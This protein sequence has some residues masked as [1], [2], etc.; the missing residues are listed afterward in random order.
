MKLG[1]HLVSFS[2]ARVDAEEGDSDRI[3]IIKIVDKQSSL[4]QAK[5]EEQIP[6]NAD[7]QG[8]CKFASPT[9][10]TYEKLYKR[11]GRMVE[12]HVE[13]QLALQCM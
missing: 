8:I 1:M 7:H 9:D 2:Y 4:L 5:V 6:V 10:E 11:M 13:R 12:A 3:V